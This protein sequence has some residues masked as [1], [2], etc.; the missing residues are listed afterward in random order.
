M[1]MRAAGHAAPDRWQGSM[2]HGIQRA[3]APV[4]FDRVE[5]DLGAVLS[6]DDAHAPECSGLDVL[7]Q[8][9]LFSRNGPWVR[10]LSDASPANSC[11]LQLERLDHSAP[12]VVLAPQERR[13]L[14]RRGRGRLERLSFER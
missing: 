11:S 10:N 6:T 5:L 8:A 12:L 1:L 7:G 13:E 9:T 2:Q 3:R 4:S 14:L